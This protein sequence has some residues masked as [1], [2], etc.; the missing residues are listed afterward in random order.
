MLHPAD[1]QFAVTS[2]SIWLR[3]CSTTIRYKG[4]TGFYVLPE[5]IFDGA[6]KWLDPDTIGTI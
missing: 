4:G 5:S 2:V 1:C 3:N 6:K